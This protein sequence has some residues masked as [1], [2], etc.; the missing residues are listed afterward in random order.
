M[1]NTAK[2][3]QP[4]NID[5][6]TAIIA[7]YRPGPM[8]QIPQYIANKRNPS[9][10][11]LRFES[12]RDVFADT[13]GCMVY[14]EQVMFAAQVLAGYPMSAA[15]ELRKGIGKKKQD[16]IDAHRKYLIHGREASGKYAAIPG[17]L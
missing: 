3:L 7:L 4:Q 1:T 10:I 5:E 17:A 14:Q 6:V 9:K 13:Y 8:D 11:R 16:L 12:L 2:D 15:D